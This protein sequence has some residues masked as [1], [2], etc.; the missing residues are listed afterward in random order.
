MCKYKLVVSGDI[1][2]LMMLDRLDIAGKPV[3]LR[4]SA[5]LETFVPKGIKGVLDKLGL[6]PTSW[7]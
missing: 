7:W 5:G 2:S 3:D 1:F 4:A 6:K